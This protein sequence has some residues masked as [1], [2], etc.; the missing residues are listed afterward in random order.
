MYNTNDPFMLLS[1]INMKLR[2][3]YSS[4]DDYCQSENKKKEDIISLL[5]SIG[6]TY[7]ENQNQFV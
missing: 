2:D 1:I 3:T 4:L 5:L 7:D 6:Y